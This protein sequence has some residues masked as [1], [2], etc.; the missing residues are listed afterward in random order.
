MSNAILLNKINRTIEKLSLTD[1]SIIVLKGIPMSVVSPES[2]VGLLDDIVRNKL[3]YF[4][5][6]FEQ[7]KYLTYEEF[8]LL[9][10]F[11]LDQYDKIYVLN[12]N[13]YMTQ[14]PVDAEFSG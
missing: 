11:V 14:Y 3:S 2:N 13:L 6:I 4:M 12:N 8:L 1:N 5:S 10:S 9:N 7:R